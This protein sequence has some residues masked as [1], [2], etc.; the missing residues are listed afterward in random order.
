MSS[1]PQFT[2]KQK[3]IIASKK[4]KKSEKSEKQVE[5]VAVEADYKDGK[6]V[7]FVQN[8]SDYRLVMKDYDPA[9]NKFSPVMT[10][11]EL[12]GILGKRK[13]QLSN[14]AKT[15][16]NIKPGM[17]LD[18]I[19]EQELRERETPYLLKRTSGTIT[20]YWRLEDMEINI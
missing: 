6:T 16:I 8:V 20:E 14:G 17:S 2:P 10:S 3:A 13:T 9:K 5:V 15:S 19:V 7:D 12:S 18:D 11:W 4:S 1:K